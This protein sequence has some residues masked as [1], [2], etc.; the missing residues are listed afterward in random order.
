[1]LPASEEKRWRSLLAEAGPAADAGYTGDAGTADDAGAAN[2]A[3]AANFS[4]GVSR[5]Y[6]YIPTAETASFL[7]EIHKSCSGRE[8]LGRD[9]L[10]VV[11][12]YPDGED[13]EVAG[14]V[15]SVLAFGSVDLIMDACR[16]A[17]APLGP[18]PAVVLDRMDEAAV[19][20]AWS[21]FQY[22][23]CFPRD[24]IALMRGIRDARRACGSLEGLFARGDPEGSRLAVSASRFV[25]GLRGYMEGPAGRGG[26][27][28]PIRANLLPDPIDG[29]ACKRLFLF[30]R[31]MGRRDEVDP[32]VWS[33]LSPS[34]LIVPLDVHMYATCRARL[35]F[36]PPGRASRSPN[37]K[38]AL[39]ATRLFALYA[40]DDPV[41]YDFALTRP[42]ID[43]RPGDEIYGCL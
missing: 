14:M 7:E 18:H 21:G 17:L 41:K 29:S 37:L 15:C 3:G 12:E 27:P 32:G 20:G 36:F 23:F 11:L 30:L 5:P 33:C 6:G 13:R 34:R 28:G 38:D 39:R 19:S 31:W 24:M 25:K 10:A 35:G 43:P 4:G 22:R 16:R 2:C 9:P 8:R 42:G 40:P 26:S 1:M